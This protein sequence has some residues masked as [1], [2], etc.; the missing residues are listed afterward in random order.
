MKVTILHNL[1]QRGMKDEKQQF[2][3]NFVLFFS[4]C[5]INQLDPRTFFDRDFDENRCI[6]SPRGP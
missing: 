3:R 4:Y 2:C 5:G 6:C 1:Y